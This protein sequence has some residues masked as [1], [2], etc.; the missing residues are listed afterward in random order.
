MSKRKTYNKWKGFFRSKGIDEKISKKYLSYIKHLLDNN[1][2][3]IFEFDHLS[4][5]LGK[6]PAYL[7]SAV[8]SPDNYYRS[9]KLK[10]RT[11]GFREINVP[12]PSLLDCQYWIYYNILL[13]IPIHR[14]SHG[15]SKN[16]SIVTNARI[17]LNQNNVLKIDLKNFFPS[18]EIQRVIHVFKMVG[19]PNIIAY[20]LASL[21]CFEECLPQ[22]APTSPY[23]CNLVSTKLDTRLFSFAK[24]FNLRYTRYP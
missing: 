4:G 9:F 3:I 18:I 2:P 22:G 7:A 16:K 24:K 23:L 10:K 20:Y 19:Y 17:H 15:F 1:V 8:N 12:F 5:L 6:T 21:C 13:K 14:C 11:G